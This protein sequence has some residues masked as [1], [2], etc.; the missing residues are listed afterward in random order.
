MKWLIFLLVVINF[1]GC[2]S[3]INGGKKDLLFYS[4]EE[5][6]T[7]TVENEDTH[8][9]VKQKNSVKYPTKKDRLF[10]KASKKGCEPVSFFVDS[11]VSLGWYVLGNMISFFY[12]GWIFDPILGGL[13]YYDAKEFNVTPNC[14]YDSQE[15]DLP[16]KAT[17]KKVTP[18][19]A[20]EPAAKVQES[21]S[22]LFVAVL[23][24]SARDEVLDHESRLY[25]T[26][27][28]R[29]YAN[30]SLPVQKGFSIMTREN[31]RVMLPPE[32]S[33]EECEGSCLAETG[34]NI[35]AD[36][37]AQARVGKF[38]ALFTVTV[39]LY[40]TKSA[41]L[42]SSFTARAEN[43]EELLVQIEKNVSELFNSVLHDSNR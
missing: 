41:K 40:E 15:E 42:L 36:Y 14:D 30:K 13:W 6:T 12:F 23:E 8:E 29:Q 18:K 16:P 19:N 9:I 5:N 1:C 26:D 21:Y 27:M 33:L 39:E 38:K 37:V 32:S 20:D 3:I 35:S 2:A 7:I 43:E 17:A 22:Q 34:R 4:N 25:M 11:K 10:V 28:L 31:I 24:T